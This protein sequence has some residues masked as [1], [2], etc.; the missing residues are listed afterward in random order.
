MPAPFRKTEGVRPILR[1]PQEGT[2]IILAVFTGDSTAFMIGTVA[3]RTSTLML[4]TFNAWY[5]TIKCQR[6]LQ[7]H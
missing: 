2:I 3:A 4:Q 6:R 1:F 7:C 5:F